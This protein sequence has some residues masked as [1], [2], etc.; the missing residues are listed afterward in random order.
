MNAEILAMAVAMAMRTI[1]IL[2]KNV[3]R[4]A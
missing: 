3:Q 2:W 4:N 1:L